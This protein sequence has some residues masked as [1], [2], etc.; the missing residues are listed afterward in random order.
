MKTGKREVFTQGVPG[1]T[2]VGENTTKIPVIR[3]V[4]TIHIS[5]FALESAGGS[6]KTLRVRK[7]RG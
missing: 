3:E 2:I 1:K 7:R 4:K 5:D 6:E